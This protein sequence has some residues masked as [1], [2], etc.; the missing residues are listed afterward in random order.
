MESEF[1]IE[2]G[3]LGPKA[4]HG[5]TW[6]DILNYIFQD[7][8][9]WRRNYFPEDEQ[10]LDRG[11]RRNNEAWFDILSNN[12]DSVLNQ[13]KADYPFY[14]P[15]YQG[16]MITE[17]LVSGMMGYFAGM[18]YNPNNVSTESAPITLDLELESGRMIAKMLGYDTTKS[19]SH[20]S[21]GGTIAN[22]EALWAARQ[23]QLNG[24]AFSHVCQQYDIELRIRIANGTEIDIRE[25]TKSQ[26]ISLP[27]DI[28]VE[29]P[30]LFEQA[31]AK[32]TQLPSTGELLKEVK[33]GPYSITENGLSEVYAKLDIKPVI[34]VSQAAHYSIRKITNILGLGEKHVKFLAVDEHFR[35]DLKKLKKTILGLRENQPILAMIGILGTTEEGAI[36]PIHEMLA[37]RK[38]I[39]KDHCKSFWFHIDAAW[40]GYL[41]T[42]KKEEPLLSPYVKTVLQ[43]VHEADSITIDPH[44]MGYI[45]YPSG[46]I[47]FKNKFAVIHSHQVAPYITL[48]RE[49]PNPLNIED[50][51]ES[52][53][54]YIIEGSKPGAAAVAT[55]LTHKTIP[56]NPSGHGK[57]I[58]A[59]IENA[60]YFHKLIED[61]KSPSDD[62]IQLHPIEVP[63]C[64]VL[65][66]YFSIKGNESVEDQN[67]LNKGI[68]QA[69]SLNTSQEK[70]MMPYRQEF[71]I[72]HTHFFPSH[73]GFESIAHLIRDFPD[74]KI[75]YEQNG[76]FLLRSVIINPWLNRS[77]AKNMDYLKSLIN[78][79]YK[80]ASI[81][82]Q[83]EHAQAN[84]MAA[85]V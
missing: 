5:K 68:Y 36:D 71:F 77:K 27:P 57:L 14:S 13:L 9:H 65:C 3:F 62:A 7:Y 39:E 82:Y 73:Y 37:M 15:R 44:K 10:V 30:M 76:I 81:I 83:Q 55:W 45:P 60:Q 59:S 20:I 34:L 42:L 11:T 28:Q 29:L 12:L 8:I 22:M 43:S 78:Q 84:Y 79:L 49:V 38:E 53:G 66:Y 80:T 25:A 21:S 61:S 70:H 46:V 85:P 16:H 2:A 51:N 64:N 23:N 75:Q 47:N 19:W 56:L 33:Y 17:N 48:D 50:L 40:G 26:L 52:V 18:L 1:P 41:K 58:K 72:S 4:E 63:D 6:S 67:R 32:N 31:T 69:F 54:P 35:V 24:M 74:A